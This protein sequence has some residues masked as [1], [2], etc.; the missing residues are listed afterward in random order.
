MQNQKLLPR[1]K[2]HERGLTLIETM[3]VLAIIG[4]L[5]AIAL[6]YYQ[7]YVLEN[8]AKSATTDLI[9]LSQTLENRFKKT[10]SYP[11]YSASTLID[12][13]PSARPESVASDFGAWTPSQGKWF[14]YSI[15]STPSTY[16]VF[17]TGMGTMKCTLSLDYKNTR[18]ASGS[19]CGF[20]AW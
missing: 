19:S 6:P 10:S 2:P 16:T 1:K 18:T 20:N 17:A 3:T 7:A 5:A 14:T 4:I 13:T 9:A 11:V 15:V 8:R 12:A